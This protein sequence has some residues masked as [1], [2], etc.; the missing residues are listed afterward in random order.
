V[1]Q[2]PLLVAW[3]PPAALQ[4]HHLPLLMLLLLQLLRQLRFVQLM[5]AVLQRLALLQDLLVW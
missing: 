3:C 4:Q 1:G 2:L 5:L